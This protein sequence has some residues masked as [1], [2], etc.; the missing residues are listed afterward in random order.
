MVLEYLTLNFLEVE[1]NILYSYK[2]VYQKKISSK[3]R[4][5]ARLKLAK[6]YEKLTN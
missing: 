4:N 3:N 5:K 6:E 2:K 1:K